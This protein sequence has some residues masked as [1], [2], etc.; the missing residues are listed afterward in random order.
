[1]RGNKR[2]IK[3]NSN[4]RAPNSVKESAPPALKDEEDQDKQYSS[5]GVGGGS[6]YVPFRSLFLISTHTRKPEQ[7]RR[8]GTS[9]TTTTTTAI[10]W[11]KTKKVKHETVACEGCR[12]MVGLR[13]FRPLLASG[14]RASEGRHVT[15]ERGD[16]EGLSDALIRTEEVKHSYRQGEFKR[17]LIS[18]HN[19][20]LNWLEWR[21]A[22]AIRVAISLLLKFTPLSKA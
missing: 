21:N 6:L 1:M 19:S 2:I 4:E 9:F 15:T 3:E 12:E 14:P 7:Q 20:Y 8:R 13:G 11:L 16:F 10:G 18:R 5:S 17:Y 22:S